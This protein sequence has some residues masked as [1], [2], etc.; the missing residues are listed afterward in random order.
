MILLNE[1]YDSPLFSS[2]NEFVQIKQNTRT[3]TV[4]INR[5]IVG[6]LVAYSTKNEKVIDFE[7]ALEYPMCSVP[8]S[9]ANPDGSCRAMTKSKLLEVIVK[10][11]DSPLQHPSHQK[12]LWGLLSSI[13]WPSLE[14]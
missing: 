7:K 3:Q 13:L 10:E 12:I 5:N 2:T 9:L 11:C 1:R 14:Q 4:E 6:T 8:L